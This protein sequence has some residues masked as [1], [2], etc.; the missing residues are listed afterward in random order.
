M[1]LSQTYICSEDQHNKFWSYE[2]QGS[3]VLYRWGRVGTPG[4]Q[5]LKSYGTALGAQMEVDKLIGE[6]KTKG[7]TLVTKQKLA[8]ETKVAKGLGAQYKISKMLFVSKKLGNVLTPLSKY[9]PHQFVYVEVLN[10]WSKEITR[11]LFS[12][13]EN[14]VIT[15]GYTEINKQ[16]TFGSIR[17]AGYSGRELDFCVTVREVLKTIAGQV[18]EA[19][20]NIQKFAAMG[21]RNL[22]DDDLE[23]STTDLSQITQEVSFSAS[24]DTSVISKF[25]SLGMRTLEL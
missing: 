6:K 18:S 9:D 7:Y 19:V 11:L 8:A 25:A 12:K 21:V 5:K 20:K 3:N 2:L 13:A 16:M 1:E 4:Q 15:G 22:G 17:G 14:F 23:V 10:S 24:V